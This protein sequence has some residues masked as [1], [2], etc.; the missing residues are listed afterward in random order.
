V[1][2]AA[3]C[4]LVPIATVYPPGAVVVESQVLTIKSN[5]N[6]STF[7]PKDHS[8]MQT[9]SLLSRI[10]CQDAASN[11]S[12]WSN[13]L[14]ETSSSQKECRLDYKSVFTHALS[15]EN[16]WNTNVFAGSPDLKFNT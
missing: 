5:L 16:F 9:E 1:A 15:I 8:G 14:P 2:I 10:V 6:V 7:N 12:T 3:F 13:I 11:L 4:W